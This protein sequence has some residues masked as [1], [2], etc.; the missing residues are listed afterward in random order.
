MS[1]P[2]GS[3]YTDM[4]LA[5]AERMFELGRTAVLQG[6]SGQTLPIRERE[7]E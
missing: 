7:E 3:D 6:A 5:T 1:N 2:T 4:P